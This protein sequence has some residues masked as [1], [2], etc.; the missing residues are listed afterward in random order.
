MKYKYT[1]TDSRVF[2]TLSIVVKPGDEFDAPDNFDVPNVVPAGAQR[3]TPA[4]SATSD[5]KVG[6]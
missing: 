2:P 1:G 5:P 3:T 4:T 6:E